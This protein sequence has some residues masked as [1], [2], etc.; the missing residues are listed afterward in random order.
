ML[1]DTESVLSPG[2]IPQELS[3][4]YRQG[5]PM[6]RGPLLPLVNAE[7]A[8]IFRGIRPVLP[9]MVMMV[10]ATFRALENT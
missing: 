9:G 7:Q 2:W 5:Q 1:G 8:R 4:R 3:Y 10:S 6:I